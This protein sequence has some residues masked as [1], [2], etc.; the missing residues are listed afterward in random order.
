MPRASSSATTLPSP[1]DMSAESARISALVSTGI[2]DTVPEP[3]FDA[4][5]EAA[6]RAY[7]CPMAAVTFIDNTRQWFKAA[8]GLSREYFLSSESLC[9][10]VVVSATPLTVLNAT[11]DPRFRAHPLV[12]ATPRVRFFASAP[13]L[14]PGTS[15]VLGTVI[16]LDTKAHSK[17]LSTERLIALAAAAGRLVVTEPCG[18]RKKLHQNAFYFPTKDGFAAARSVGPPTDP[19]DSINWCA[20]SRLR[21]VRRRDFQRIDLKPRGPIAFDAPICSASLIDEDCQRFI[22]HGKR[23]RVHRRDA[24]DAHVVRTKVAVWV[25]DTTLDPRFRDHPWVQGATS[26]PFRRPIRFYACLPI[27]FKNELL[28]TYFAMDFVPRY[29]ASFED[30]K[31]LNNDAYPHASAIEVEMALTT[32]LVCIPC[33]WVTDLVHWWK[34]RHASDA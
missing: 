28:G 13:I 8:R 19:S 26:S 16:V 32:P 10:T 24:L 3:T 7:H 34:W 1:M 4:I 21:Y 12:V 25:N 27:Y 33:A 29:N 22:V 23:V 17:A 14:L 11:K 15:V 30:W 2:L 6:A 18:G 5:C 31:A 9:S 20:S